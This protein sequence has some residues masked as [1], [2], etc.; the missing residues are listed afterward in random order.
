MSD[1]EFVD[2][3]LSRR[4]ALK[5]GLLVGG[6]LWVVPAVQ[7]VTMTEAHAETAS[8]PVSRQPVEELEV[9]RG[10]LPK[11]GAE[12]NPALVAAAGA[13]LVAAGS[14]AVVAQR[15]RK[16]ART[17]EGPAMSVA[18]EPYTD[19]TD[20]PAGPDDPELPGPRDSSG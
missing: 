11:T 16:A 19:P 5:R 18:D 2:D 12:M 6:A 3:G 8:G 20:R 13:G 15:R 14:A 9:G 17:A 1:N 10:M 4:D 7:V